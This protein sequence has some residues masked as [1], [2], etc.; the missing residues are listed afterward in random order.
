MPPVAKELEHQRGG[1]PHRVE[2]VG[3]AHVVELRFERRDC[4]RA[5]PALVA[6]LARP[7]DL[8]PELQALAVGSDADHV[9]PGDEVLHQGISLPS[10]ERNFPESRK[11]SLPITLR[12]PLMD[13]SG[14]SGAFSPPMSVRTQPGLSATTMMLRP[15]SVTESP[16]ASALSAALLVA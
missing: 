10:C 9:E 13:C 2:R 5:R 16:F 12:K 15:A 3:A 4:D 7:A 14:V 1:E 6:L 8:R 11:V